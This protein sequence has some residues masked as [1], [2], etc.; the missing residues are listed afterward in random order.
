MSW[1]GAHLALLVGLAAVAVWLVVFWMWV[2][3]AT[4]EPPHRLLVEWARRR[5]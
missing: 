4:G 5:F 1:F 2:V 3:Y